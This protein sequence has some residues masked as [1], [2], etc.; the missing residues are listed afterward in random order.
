M[1]T[2]RGMLVYNLIVVYI[3]GEIPANRLLESTDNAMQLYVKPYGAVGF[4]RSVA[5]ALRATA[6]AT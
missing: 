4:L 1:V 6:W 5:L 3:H 2:S